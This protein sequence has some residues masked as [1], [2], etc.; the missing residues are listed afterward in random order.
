MLRATARLLAL[1]LALFTAH[2]HAQERGFRVHRYEGSTAGSWLFLLERPWYSSTRYGA[3]GVTFDYGHNPLQPRVPTGRGPL[4]P[5]VSNA[6]VG[7]VDLA[8]SLFDRLLLSASLPVTFLETGSPELVSQVG[9]LQGIGVGDPRVG[10][11]VRLFGHAERD[12]F[13]AHLGADVWIPIGAQSIHQ[14][15]SGV[16]L[17][18]RAVLAGAFGA[19]RWTV[20]LGFLY[21]PYASFGPPALGMTAAP[22]ARVGIALGISLADD[23]LYLG[24][25]AQ[26]AMQVVGDNAFSLYGMNLEVLGGL[27]YLI[28]DTVLVGVAGGSAFLGA[29]GTPDAR[30]MV[31]LA[32]A[33][34][35][36]R[37][38]TKREDGPVVPPVTDDADFDGVSDVLDRCPFEP[39]T[40]NGVRD[41]DGCPEFHMEQG[42]ALARVLAPT[43]G[44]V[45][46]STPLG[47]SGSVAA[48][49]P[50]GGSG[51]STPLGVSGSV[52]A[53]SP[54]SPD[55]GS[56]P[57]TSLGGAVAAIS[58]DGGSGPSTPL[59]VSGSVAATSAATFAS[60]D[61]DGDGVIDDVD[62]C[63]VTPEDGDG[64]EDED[65]CSEPDNDGDLVADATDNCPF[66]AETL[67]ALT[68]DDGCPDLAPDADKD[69][70]A[71]GVDRCPLE[72][73]NTDGVRDE[74]GCP[75]F[76]GPTQALLSKLLTAPARVTSTPT[77][78]PG[79]TTP[80][81][82]D[83]DKDGVV[84]DDDRCPVTG[85]DRDGFEDE[86]GCSEPDNDDDGIADAKDK[87]AFEAETIN[88]WKDEDGC[89]DEDLD[90][91]KDGLDYEADRCPL[92]PGTPLDGC[93]HAP[94][95]ALALPGFAL[96]VQVAAPVAVAE[97]APVETTADFD[98]DG[99][100]DEADACPAGAEDRD[101]FEDEDGCAE[102]DNDRD[103]LV[104]AK[105]KC[106]FEAETI[107]G[108]KDD[109]GCPD[110]GPGL[111]HVRGGEVVIDDVVRFKL[112]SANLERTAPPLLKQVA[113][114]LRAVASLSI[115]IQG[116][117]D[118]TGN[119]ATNI[120]LSQKRAEAIRTFLVKAGVAPNRLVAK[121]FG[122]TRPRAT[123]KT[124]EGREQNRRVEF[125]ILG[126][127]K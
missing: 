113:S 27:H 104:D 34:R 110:S 50:D 115:E 86:D 11:M 20:D 91:D 112:A 9:P 127:A 64:F 97:A 7:H 83:S 78:V 80:A 25:E 49:S 47:V 13:S 43:P 68:D 10:L 72:P 65:G 70:V 58:P 31:R 30:A 46:P 122:P 71:D 51:P 120:K 45:G 66:E 22:E 5:I 8:G 53:L 39:E 29:A 75:E 59:G 119:A 23:R 62:R 32:F 107:N 92:E 117:T 95:P 90:A 37:T 4:T 106:P 61:S 2:A 28:G 87:C 38:E 124:A 1:S 63:P 98:K 114:T 121:G 103:G 88:G 48:I 77:F 123:N 84:D 52:A 101:G 57:S 14:G 35:R 69:G 56:G 55:A 19:G 16:R 6:L 33:P 96:P 24:P 108:K 41:A 40:K 42:S 81:P 74:D 60:A 102:P 15:D 94:L 82:R 3:V 93:P 26:F 105:D 100:N 116:H 18:P 99:S 125:L 67:N 79:E 89:P 54:D 109:D 17:L 85:E 111:V 126:E 21:R 36:E 76:A 73:E 44:K 12:P 118:D